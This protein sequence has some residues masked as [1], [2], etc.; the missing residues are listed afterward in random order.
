MSLMRSGICVRLITDQIKCIGWEC[1]FIYSL[2]KTQLT[3]PPADY[4]E[5]GQGYYVF[6]TS[7]VD[8][9]FPTWTPT[10]TP[11]VSPTTPTA[12]PTNVPSANPSWAP[13]LST[14]TPTSVQ[15]EGVAC[16]GLPCQGV[17]E[18]RSRYGYCGESIAHCNDNSIWTEDCGG[19]ATVAPNSPP[20]PIQQDL[21]IS[22]AFT[23]PAELKTTNC[24]F[25]YGPDQVLRF[26]MPTGPFTAPIGTDCY[27][28]IYAFHFMAWAAVCLCLGLLFI[29]VI[30]FR[31]KKGPLLKLQSMLLAAVCVAG[32]VLMFVSMY[33]PAL[34][35]IFY[36]VVQLVS[37]LFNNAFL[38]KQVHVRLNL[39]NGMSGSKSKTETL[40]G[41]RMVALLALCG[42]SSL[43]PIIGAVSA[44]QHTTQTTHHWRS[45]FGS[46]TPRARQFTPSSWWPLLSSCC[47]S[48][49]V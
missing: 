37:V 29:T 14:S 13:T 28:N 39:L 24:T 22:F 12:A 9:I 38:A 7:L 41:R 3:T 33:Q 45:S 35:R 44:P 4:F 18:C 27:Q 31:F 11:T 6:H 47:G 43:L 8:V 15:E 32:S 20:P 2:F 1:K 10:E 16:V 30:D 23:C 34:S 42:V 36:A 5:M 19:G 46:S 26:A 40:G 48:F 21:P 49:K 17:Y 25:G